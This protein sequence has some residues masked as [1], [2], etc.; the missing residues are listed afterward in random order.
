MPALPV[1][2]LRALNRATLARQLLLD[3]APLDPVTAIERLAGLQ[4]QEPVSPSLALLA[5]LEPFDPAALRAAFADRRLVKATLMRATLHVVS[6]TDYRRL[7]PAVAPVHAAT[8]ARNRG[9]RPSPEG[10]ARLRAAALAHASVPRRNTDLRD[11][12]ATLHD[13]PDAAP[14]DTWWWVRRH[15]ALV[16]APAP[17]PLPWTFDRR[18]WLV[19]A[20]AWLGEDGGFADEEAALNHLVRR[21]LGAFGPA[22]VA[23][24]AGWSRLPVARLRPAVDAITAGGE[25]ATFLDER[26]RQ[27]VDLVDAPRP[28]P[29]T[30]APP[31][32][33]PM[34]D[35]L[36]LGHAD[37]SR[38]ISDP[39]RARVIDVNGDTYPTILVDGQ[40]AGL[41]W[42]RRDGDGCAIELEP[43]E[44]LAAW[45]AEVRAGLADEAARVAA[46]LGPLDPEAYGRYRAGRARRHGGRT[47][48]SA[49]V[50]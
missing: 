41:W 1:L 17:A 10:L 22:T 20:D 26:G 18:P 25:T 30:P 36:V 39:H 37:R 21:Y 19:D 14:E 3:R 2:S 4:A 45:P 50:A 16:H 29:D 24:V 15:L 28:D 23:D 27:L 32:L 46:F 44:P 7:Q 13:N 40:V 34:W 31:R 5:R 35:S 48:R 12:V 47:G 8:G 33:L 9:E 38:V 49:G 6:A 43:F 11:L 42:S